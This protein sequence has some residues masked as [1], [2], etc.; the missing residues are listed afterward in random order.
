MP[1]Y[2]D[3]E[4]QSFVYVPPPVAKFASMVNMPCPLLTDMA[5]PKG[6]MDQVANQR[7]QLQ[8][9]DASP[10]TQSEFMHRQLLVRK[11]SLPFIHQASVYV[12]PVTKTLASHPSCQ[13]LSLRRQVI[14]E[15]APGN[16]T[17]EEGRKVTCLELVQLVWGW[18]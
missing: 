16:P 4:S 5:D 9:K 10:I 11:N 7:T 3:P 8:E 15:S 6:H 18:N 12:T 13:F 2:Y 17:D 1:H 14:P